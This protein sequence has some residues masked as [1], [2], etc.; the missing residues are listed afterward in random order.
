MIT[1]STDYANKETNAYIKANYRKLPWDRRPRF[2]T[3]FWSRAMWVEDHVTLCL[4]R[5][6]WVRTLFVV[7]RV[8]L[9]IFYFTLSLHFTPGLQSAVCILPSVCILP[10]VCSL[11]SA[12]CSLQSAVCVLHWPINPHKIKEADDPEVPRHLCCI[13][14]KTT[15]FNERCWSTGYSPSTPSASFSMRSRLSLYQCT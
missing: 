4:F 2:P 7:T 15:I 1:Y 14:L 8:L 9:L 11:Q 12:V 3:C 13:L 10:P 6:S 5:E